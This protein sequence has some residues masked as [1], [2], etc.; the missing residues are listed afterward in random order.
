MQDKGHRY[1]GGS[2]QWLVWGVRGVLWVSLEGG[3]W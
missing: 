2:N 1:E 3:D